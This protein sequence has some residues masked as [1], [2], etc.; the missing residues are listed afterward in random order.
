MFPLHILQVSTL[1]EFTASSLRTVVSMHVNGVWDVRSVFRRVMTFFDVRRII[2]HK[3]V[4]L[5]T[6]LNT[7]Y[8]KVVK[9]ERGSDHHWLLHH[10]NTSSHNSLNVQQYLTK[11]AVTAIPHSLYSKPE[12]MWLF[13]ISTIQA[14]N[15]REM[16]PDNR[17]NL[18]HDKKK[19][20]QN[21]T[22]W[23]SML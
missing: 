7:L 23:F 5:G 6:A 14:D 19:T 12:S 1:T 13:F 17:R 20:T 18:T 15:E 2:H 16:V 8:Y 4:E 9:K 3:F 11:K 22:R 10:D 21:Y